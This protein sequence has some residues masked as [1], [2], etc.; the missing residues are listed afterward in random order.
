MG[1]SAT[2]TLVSLKSA[3]PLLHPYH[4]Q[5]TYTEIL[6]AHLIM[7]DDKPVIPKLDK[8]GSNWVTYRDCLILAVEAR[9]L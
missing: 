4:H 6:P 9:I 3:K 1:I 7:S 8:D 5:T 2:E